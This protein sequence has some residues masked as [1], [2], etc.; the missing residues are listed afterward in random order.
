MQFL[1]SVFFLQNFKWTVREPCLIHRHSL[2]TLTSAVPSI[3]APP[4]D[5]RSYEYH[6]PSVSNGAAGNS[7]RVT[8]PTSELNR[9]PEEDGFP[10]IEGIHAVLQR[11]RAME[12]PTLPP[13]API[14]PQT[15]KTTKQYFDD[16]ERHEF[17]ANNY[18]LPKP[19]DR[20]RDHHNN[21]I[22]SG[23]AATV[24]VNGFHDDSIGLNYF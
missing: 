18:K 21:V 14:L 12:D 16:G 15:T 6:P 11:F 24:A 23:D 19:D 8:W 10:T 22:G 7:E 17:S 13:P 5:S 1:S 20:Q 9:E 4:A 3:V 2:S